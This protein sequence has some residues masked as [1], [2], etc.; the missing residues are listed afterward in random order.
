MY[1]Q[2]KADQETIRGM[3]PEA[4]HCQWLKESPSACD[5]LPRDIAGVKAGCPCPNNPFYKY[6]DL[7]QINTDNSIINEEARR[8]EAL[9]DLG[10]VPDLEK[11]S[12]I[13]FAFAAVV[14]RYLKA[15][16]KAN[17]VRMF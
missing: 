14:R 4:A 11:L 5:E 1:Q 13:Q 10:I 9:I 7:I 8:W 3:F 15:V 16:E 17:S 2:N 6:A 12:A